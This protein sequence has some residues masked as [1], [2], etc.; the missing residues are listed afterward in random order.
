MI[1]YIFMG[2]LVLAL[3]SFV[4]YTIHHIKELDY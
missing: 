2:L 4:V 1:V 3:V